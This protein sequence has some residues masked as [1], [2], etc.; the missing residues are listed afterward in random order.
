MVR[1]P[2]G[3]RYW[4]VIDAEFRAEPVTDRFLRERRFGRDRVE[5]TT[6]AYA[7]GVAL[8]LTWCETTGRAWR[9]AAADLGLFTAQGEGGNLRV[10]LRARHR[11]Q[12][13]DIAV[14]R[15]SDEE[16]V[17]LFGACRSARDRLIVLP[18]SRAGLRRGE[19]AGLRRC[20]LHLLP[21]NR[22]VGCAVD[23]AHLHVIR[24]DNSNGGVGEVAV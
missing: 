7:G 13:P 2:S 11:L 1:M 23:G 20:D 18:L 4:T 5:S 12:E 17:A 3:G 19:A 21:D 22:P 9:S 14:D 8:F 10:R 15:A 6:K 24:R 16:I